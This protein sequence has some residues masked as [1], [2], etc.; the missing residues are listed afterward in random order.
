MRKSRRSKAQLHQSRPQAAA[1][2]PTTPPPSVECKSTPE[3]LIPVCAAVA[4]VI[5]NS[6]GVNS[7]ATS[8][9]LEEL[10]RERTKQKSLV[11]DLLMDKLEAHKQRSAEKRAKRAARTASLA[12]SCSPHRTTPQPPEEEKSGIDSTPKG[13]YSALSFMPRTCTEALT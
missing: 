8:R 2:P 4:S 6:N 9:K 13:E 7:P 1:P 3:P 11:Q 5:A 10:T 12:A